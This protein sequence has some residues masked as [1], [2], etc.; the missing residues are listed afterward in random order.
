MVLVGFGAL[1]IFAPSCKA[2]SEVSADH[3][4]GTDTWE[5]ATRKPI[6]PKAKAAPALAVFQAKDKKANANASLQLA[7]VRENSVAMPRN[8][9][10]LE[11]KKKPAVRKSDKE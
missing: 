8:S 2:Q 11:D 1:V 4:D 6:G 10:A 3:F 5:V 9:A 7:S